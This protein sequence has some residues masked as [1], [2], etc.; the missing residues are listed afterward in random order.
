MYHSVAL[1]LSTIGSALCWA[2]QVPIGVQL[3]ANANSL[4]NITLPYGTYQARSYQLNGD[5][6]ADT[7]IDENWVKLTSL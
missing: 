3:D 7:T 6:S 1:L 5:V 2:A 4:P